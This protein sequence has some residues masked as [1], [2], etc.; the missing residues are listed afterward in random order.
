MAHRPC[1][2]RFG[3]LCLL[4]FFS[5]ESRCL[6]AEDDFAATVAPFLKQHCQSCHGADVQEARIRYDR[7]TDFRAEDR[8]LWTKVHEMLSAGKMP[9][10]EQP[11]PSEKEKTA[12]L[13]WIET[14]QRALD[15][16]S[17]RRLNRRELSAALQDLTGRDIDYAY[18]LPGD[19]TVSGFDTGA[20][21]LQDAA[22]SVA[23]MMDVTRQA[24]DAIR[25]LEESSGPV[26]S[27]DLRD[28]KDVRRAPILGK[29]TGPIPNCA[30]KAN[31]GW[32]C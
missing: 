14:N 24:V 10:K 3:V 9:P 22:S 26:F 13:S 19:G 12:V 25:F 1:L 15:A 5:L 21:G 7:M 28:V 31:G 8:H 6:L 2:L 4:V 23:R 16:G 29:K 11:Q 27:A 17:T 30:A 18:S 32:A 20:E